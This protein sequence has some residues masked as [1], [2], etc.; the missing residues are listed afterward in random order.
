MLFVTKRFLPIALAA[1][2]FIF[3]IISGCNKLDTTTLGSDLIPAIDNVNTFADTFD[4]RTTQGIFNDSFKILKTENNVLGLI[5]N[6][7]VFGRTDARMFFQLKP[8]FFPY[9]FGN[10]G[11]TL[12]A[13]DSVVLGL[14]YKGVWGD[15]TV[16]QN[17]EVYEILDSEFGDSTSHVKNIRYEPTQLGPLVGSA[18]ID[19]RTVAGKKYILNGKDSVTGQVRI[20]LNETFRAKLAS[21]DS[22]LTSVKNGFRSD[23][24]FRKMFKGLAVKSSAGNAIMYISLTDATTRLEVYLRKR[25]ANRIDTTYNSL[26]INTADLGTN[27]PSRSSDFISR[28]YSPEITSNLGNLNPTSLY[29]QTGPGTYANLTIDELTGLTNRIVHRASIYMEQAPVNGTTDSIFSAPPYMY[30]DLVDTGATKWKPV[31]FDLSPNTTYDPDNLTGFP[32]FPG[33]GT[34]DHNYFGSF[35]RTRFNALGQKVVYYDINVTRHVQRI[36]TK[37]TPNYSMRLYPAFRM[38]YPQYPGATEIPYDN[39]AAF[40][41][42]KLKSG[43][44]SNGDMRMKMV[45]IW[46][47]I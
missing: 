27:L 7:P 29:L 5:N 43:H 47:K 17:L 26:R 22:L 20:K 4:I 1:F 46:S 42:I 45:I 11:D 18:S 6:D 38:Y 24:I 44:P 9:Y 30:L 15:T 8:S 14:S 23:S 21:Q 39:P 41:R 32:Y 10:A 35:A 28:A 3:S 25:N 16:S 2:L 13:V 36:A 33:D 37:R 31:Y 34:V 19:L 12:I 40:G